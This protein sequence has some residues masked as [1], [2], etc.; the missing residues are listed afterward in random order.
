MSTRLSSRFKA[1]ASLAV[2]LAVLLGGY[3]L[4]G[5][6]NDDGPGGDSGAPASR[7]GTADANA[8]LTA[9][10][11]GSRYDLEGDERR[12]GHTLSRHVGKTDAE[13]VARLKSEPD[14]SAA[15]SYTDKPTAERMVAEVLNA[16]RSQV[17]RWESGSSHPNLAVRAK[18][19]EVIGRS[20][21][22][23]S[24]KVQDVRAAVVVLS[25]AERD[26]FVL[27]SYPEAR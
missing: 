15:S 7:V 24:S 19:S 18:G 17:S 2:V 22:R 25:W 5:V 9:T 23:G 4:A 26:W 13:L 16:N 8:S 12:G 1:L 3:L 6:V 27:T 11:V 20:V 10:P 21:S 14:I